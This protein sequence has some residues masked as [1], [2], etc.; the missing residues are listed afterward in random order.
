MAVFV[1]VVLIVAV[2]VVVVLVVAVFVV[3]V[4]VVAV[5]VVAIFV[6]VVLVV[7]V[8]W[9]GQVVTAVIAVEFIS[10]FSVLCKEVDVGGGGFGHRGAEVVDQ[11]RLEIKGGFAAGHGVGSNSNRTVAVQVGEGSLDPRLQTEAVIE[12]HVSLVQADNVLC[13]RFVVVDRDI[14][15]AHHLNRNQIAANRRSELFDVIRR[16]DDGTQRL[17]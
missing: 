15:G 11:Q 16:G 3:V 5:F 14:H 2:F 17:G 8:L 6:M 1:V 13:G 9:E 10:V 4:L 7:I 12:E